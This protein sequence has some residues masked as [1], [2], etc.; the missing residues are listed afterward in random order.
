M[1]E[2]MIRDR[3]NEYKYNM[4]TCSDVYEIKPRRIP[5]A[6]KDKLKVELGK[7][8]VDGIIPKVIQSH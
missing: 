3:S 5:V 8:E 1:L 2:F 7:L 4:D 6:V